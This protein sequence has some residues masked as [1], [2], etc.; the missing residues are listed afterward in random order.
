MCAW[1]AGWPA[2]VVVPI[3]PTCLLYF[4]AESQHAGLWFQCAT[5]VFLG[6]TVGLWLSRFPFLECFLKPSLKLVFNLILNS[7]WTC[8]FFV[9]GPDLRKFNVE[10]EGSQEARA[11][12]T[13]S[14]WCKGLTELPCEI[15]CWL[16]D[17]L[18]LVK[19]APPLHCE[20]NQHCRTVMEWYSKMW[21]FLLWS[22]V[23]QCN[24][25]WN[26]SL[27]KCTSCLLVRMYTSIFA[28]TSF[29]IHGF[30]FYWDQPVKSF[31]MPI[32]MGL[33][34]KRKREK[35]EEENRSQV[36]QLVC[37]FSLSGSPLIFLEGQRWER[38]KDK[39]KEEKYMELVSFRDC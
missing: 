18:F 7:K 39:A 14:S 35:L 34:I 31:K 38:W 3:H 4:R 16:L 11:G 1:L 10:L 32:N 30:W 5:T 21:C 2:S 6:L 12:K 15:F 25:G 19:R 9:F 22:I 13:C 20:R 8:L 17:F 23:D 24:S 36:L 33:N 28:L 29:W 27:C 37:L 26:F